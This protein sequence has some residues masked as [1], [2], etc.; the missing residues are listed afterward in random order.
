MMPERIG[1]IGST[2]GVKLSSSPNAKK[3]TRIRAK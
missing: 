3:P 2:Q 1:I